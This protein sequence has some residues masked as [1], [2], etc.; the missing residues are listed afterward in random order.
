MRLHGVRIDSGEIEATDTLDYVP[1]EQWHSLLL[2][3]ATYIGIALRH[4]CRCLV[5]FVADAEVMWRAGVGRFTSTDDMIRN[6]LHVEPDE[7]RLAVEYLRIADPN[8]RV[9]VPLDV[10]VARAKEMRERDAADREV[11]EGQPHGG[12]RRSEAYRERDAADRD[13]I[14][15]DNNGIGVKLDYPTGNSIAA[16]LRRLRGQRPE[17]HARVLAGELTA[18]A[19]MVEAGFRKPRPLRRRTAY[20]RILALLPRLTVEE[21]AELKDAL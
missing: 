17:L 15:L 3:R 14:K 4:D 18:H 2:K 13:R 12:D 21:R 6:G 9:P 8:L 5:Q 20:E 10:A 7:I 16:A 19:A 11:L 1:R